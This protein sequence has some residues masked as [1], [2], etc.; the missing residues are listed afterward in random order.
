MLDEEGKTYKKKF[1]MSYHKYLLNRTIP[2][3][4]ILKQN[5]ITLIVK[6]LLLFFVWFAPQ[7]QCSASIWKTTNYKNLFHKI[8]LSPYILVQIN[9]MPISQ[10]CPM[11][12]INNIQLVVWLWKWPYCIA[13]ESQ[14]VSSCVLLL[15]LPWTPFLYIQKVGTLLICLFL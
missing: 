12:E 2:R 14:T 11:F 9:Q 4:N 3:Q 6:T 15:L 7:G 5:I 13:G 8:N 10:G 1:S